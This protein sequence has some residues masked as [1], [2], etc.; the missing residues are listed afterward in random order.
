M[1]NKEGTIKERIE[2]I[3]G[4]KN[5]ETLNE[6]KDIMDLLKNIENEND[7]NEKNN[8]LLEYI[9]NYLAMKE[10][11][12]TAKEDFLFLNK[13][14]ESLRKQEVRRSDS[15][16]PAVFK[17]KD[18]MGE[19]IYFLTRQALEEYEEINKKECKDIVVI[20]SN[21]NIELAKLLDIIK[22]NF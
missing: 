1:E 17:I 22:R 3:I 5:I 8:K 2:K 4:N 20:P 21:N 7:L 6:E 15:S 14:A 16:N 10:K 18:S 9:D 19:D 12:R 13:L 11:M